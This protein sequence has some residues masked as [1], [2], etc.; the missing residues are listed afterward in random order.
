MMIRPSL[1]ALI[2]VMATQGLCQDLDPGL[3][4]DGVGLPGSDIPLEI[5]TPPSG[6]DP[7]A[8]GE[9]GDEAAPT[10]DPLFIEEQ[11]QALSHVP[12]EDS[13]LEAVDQGLLARADQ[14]GCDPD[15]GD[16]EESE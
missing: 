12:D 16:F 3:P 14:P 5:D 15:L 10:L 13:C 11:S 8:S 7:V 4:T 1:S 9:L 2:L 6:N